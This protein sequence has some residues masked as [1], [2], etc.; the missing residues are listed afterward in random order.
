VFMSQHEAIEALRP[1][2]DWS[3]YSDHVDIH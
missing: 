1:E 2:P 3:Q